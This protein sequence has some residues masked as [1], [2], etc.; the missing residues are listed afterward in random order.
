MKVTV[1]LKHLR[2]P[3]VIVLDPST[4]TLPQQRSLLGHPG[5]C[6]HPA[7]IHHCLPASDNE[8]QPGELPYALRKISYY[9]LQE[10][11]TALCHITMRL[12]PKLTRGLCLPADS[13]ASGGKLPVSMQ[14]AVSPRHT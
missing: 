6:I 4:Q 9:P 14:L 8:D 11:R 7:P 1:L 10:D 5:P 3:V 13:P 12:W 2:L